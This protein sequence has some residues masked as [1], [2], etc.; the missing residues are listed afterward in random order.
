M[1]SRKL[2]ALIELT[3][4]LNVLIVF[5]V[6]VVASLIAGGE[7]ADWKRIALAALAGSLIAAGGYAIN[8]Y[9]DIDIDSMNRPHRP[10]PRGDVLPTEAWWLWRMSSSA[11]VIGCAF[12]GPWPLAIA[13]CWVASLYAYSRW[14]KRRVLVGNVVVS[15][16]TGLAFI[17]GGA[18]VGS[19]DR[20]WMP[21]LFAFLVNLA[22]EVVKDIE[23]IEGDRKGNA[24][25][26][27]IRYGVTSALSLATAVL[28]VLIGLTLGA[29]RWGYY[30]QRYLVAI[31]VVDL[32]LVV[33][34]ILLWQ[35]QTTTS[36]RRVSVG[37]KVAMLS[38]LAALYWGSVA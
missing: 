13:L 6:I 38:G 32:L 35:S 7:F 37:L 8:D 5:A 14:L 12:L 9:Y 28:L 4:P 36:L 27:P 24:H 15:G 33:L 11:G 18:V 20:S 22:R 3:R 1:N 16:A 25:T 31:A 21:A 30:S 26:L 10:I 29:Y 19:L 23:D 2:R 17:F 34:I